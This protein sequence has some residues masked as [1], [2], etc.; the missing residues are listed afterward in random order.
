MIDS[1][2]VDDGLTG[3]KDVQ[4]AI[5][6]REQLQELFSRAGFQLKKWNSSDPA[7]MSTIPDDLKEVNQV[8][9]IS[10]KDCQFA[11]TLPIRKNPGD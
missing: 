7:V 5:T 11:K 10:G 3:A 6:L 4:T 1:F 9:N 2:Y 8:M